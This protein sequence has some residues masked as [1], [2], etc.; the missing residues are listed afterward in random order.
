MPRTPQSQKTNKSQL[1][2]ITRF[3]IVFLLTKLRKYAIFN[4][5]YIYIQKRY[6]ET[7]DTSEM[8]KRA[9]DGASPVRVCF[10]ENPSVSCTPN[11]FRK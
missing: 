7:V 2:I 11:A 8:F 9:G 1:I 3:V 6:A 4:K 10:V 5:Y